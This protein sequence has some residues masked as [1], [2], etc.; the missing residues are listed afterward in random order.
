MSELSPLTTRECLELLASQHFGRLAYTDQALPTIRPVNFVLH[1]GDVVVRTS[2]SG[3]MSRL[4]GQIVAFEVDSVDPVTQTGWSVV[5][6]GKVRPV[7]DVDELVALADPMHR[8]W[9]PGERAYFFRISTELVSGRTL[10]NSR[11]KSAE[12]S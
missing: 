11:A 4:A 10:H 1:N 3:S 7:A 5:V 9:A 8:P 6:V 2:V 12:A